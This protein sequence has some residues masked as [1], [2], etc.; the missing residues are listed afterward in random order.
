MSKY[1]LILIVLFSFAL[2]GCETM[3][4]AG[5]DLEKAGEAVQK[6]AD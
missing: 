6:A 3:A 4:G 5:R 2:V 1:F